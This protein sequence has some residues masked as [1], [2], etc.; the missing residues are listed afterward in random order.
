MDNRVFGKKIKLQPNNLLSISQIVR[1]IIMSKKLSH[2]CRG[3]N[4][5]F[6]RFIWFVAAVLMPV[7]RLLGLEKKPDW[8]LE[9]LPECELEELPE[10]YKTKASKI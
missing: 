9:D 4:I 1:M 5:M 2:L 10:D 3:T 7:K 6:T 8:K